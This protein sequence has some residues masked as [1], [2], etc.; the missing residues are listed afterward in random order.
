[1]ELLSLRIALVDPKDLMLGSLS[2]GE[3]A[4]CCVV[5]IVA[6]SLRGSSGFG[7][8]IGLPLLAVV[9]PVKVLA[10]AWS[11]LG[12]SSSIGILGQDRK[13]M[14]MRPFLLAMPWC[15]L[16]IGLGLYLF[17]T[18]NADSLATALGVLILIY[19]GYSLW[20]TTRP[21]LPDPL[22]APPLRGLVAVLS[23]AVGTTFGAMATIFF[24]I[25]LNGFRLHKQAYRATM[26]AML[27]TL[28]MIR[29]GAY[30]VVEEMTI[31]AVAIFAA[32]FP[33]MAIG[34]YLGNKVH[35]KVSEIAFKRLICGI[36][37]LSAVPLLFK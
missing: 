33:A 32:A 26:S 22:S 8:V 30:I 5:L 35:S 4:Y 7:S 37:A 34:L 12:I 25:Y 6:Y 29:V 10:P 15:A 19:A 17:K 9:I 18:M 1:M 21:T 27:L 11:L 14:A 36:L 2:V 20:L 28:S 13:H 31:E 3:I 24:A 16:G 23:G